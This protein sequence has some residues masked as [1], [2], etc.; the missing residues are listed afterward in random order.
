M[1]VYYAFFQVTWVVVT[2]ALY[3]QRKGHDSF[4]VIAT[5]KETDKVGVRRRGS[6][7][8]H[9]S[10]YVSIRQERETDKVRVRRGG[11]Q[12]RERSLLV[13]D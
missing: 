5:K 8:Q 11:R 1:C 3:R 7:R 13:H 4:L 9:T 6:I 12:V 2:I 10:A